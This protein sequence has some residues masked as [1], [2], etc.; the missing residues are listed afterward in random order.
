MRGRSIWLIIAS[1][2]GIASR[3]H[4]DA[5]GRVE[6]TLPP[7]RYRVK[8]IATPTFQGS[9]IDV[10]APSF[11]L[12][13]NGCGDLGTLFVDVQCTYCEFR[14]G[15]IT[16]FRSWELVAARCGDPR[17]VGQ[18]ELQPGTPWSQLSQQ[19]APHGDPS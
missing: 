10:D 4:V 15:P 16:P 13:A 5:S 9:P 19:M 18:S 8:A 11:E 6:V 14:V 17:A 12:A 7:G 3:H 2:G 1:A